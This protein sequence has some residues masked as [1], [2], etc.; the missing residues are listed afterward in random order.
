MLAFIKIFDIIPGWAWA[1]LFAAAV[2]VNCGNVAQRNAARVQAAEAKTALAQQGE[3]HAV[4]LEQET[5]KV[6]ELQGL[7]NDAWMA[8]ETKDAEA[9]NTIEGLREDL[10]RRSRAGGGGGLRDPHAAACPRGAA[11]AQGA[12]DAGAD[13][14]DPPEAGGLL[15]APL[16]RLLLDTIA[17]ADAIN[18]AY[19]SCHERT[20]TL[21]RILNTQLS[22]PAPGLQVPAPP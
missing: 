16:E 14:A 21:E 15:S 22:P 4:A 8:Q 9:K 6:W 2:L 13:A 7:L 18:I 3:R 19:A 5:R 11:P 17:Q 1:A 12:A 10:R 20:L